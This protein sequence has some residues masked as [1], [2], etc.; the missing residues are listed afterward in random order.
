MFAL[1][2]F[3]LFMCVVG[4]IF[5]CCNLTANASRKKVI[6]V[7]LR[8]FGGVNEWSVQALT[9]CFAMDI[10]TLATAIGTI[11]MPGTLMMS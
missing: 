8:G 3:A 1:G 2:L 9:G 10:G 4:T 6:R 11:A 5:Q 7:T